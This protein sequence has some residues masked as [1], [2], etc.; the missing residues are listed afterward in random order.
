[1]DM[2]GKGKPWLAIYTLIPI[3]IISLLLNYYFI[4]VLGILGAAISTSLAMGLASILYLFFYSREV[5]ISIL[6]I[7]TPKK[8]D[9]D[10]VNNILKKKKYNE[11]L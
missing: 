10:F 11:S 3:S 6:R 9:W 2:A 1:M 4:Q 5:D 8:S 7:I